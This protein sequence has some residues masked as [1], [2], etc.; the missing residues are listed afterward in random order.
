VKVS[1]VGKIDLDK[2][3]TKT[4][5]DKQKKSEKPVEEK[6]REAGRTCKTGGKS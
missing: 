6:P 2:L 4:R 3:N 5:P 1:V